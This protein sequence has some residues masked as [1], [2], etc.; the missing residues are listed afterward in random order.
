LLAS[1]GMPK[2]RR[3]FVRSFVVHCLGVRCEFYGVLQKRLRQ[4]NE[5]GM[6]DVRHPFL[7]DSVDSGTFHEKNQFFPKTINLGFVSL[8]SH[9]VHIDFPPLVGVDRRVAWLQRG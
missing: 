9:D 8:F 3:C 7:L 4:K 5:N 1:D 6:K 2:R